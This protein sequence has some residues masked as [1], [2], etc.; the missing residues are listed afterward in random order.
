MEVRSPAQFLHQRVREMSVSVVLLVAEAALLAV[1][2]FWWWPAAV[3]AFVPLF[4]LGR[5]ASVGGRLDSVRLQRG[6]VGEERVASLL[7]ALQP[8]GFTVIH[9]LEIGRGNADHVL[10]GPTGVFVIETKD[11]GGRFYR[12]RGRLMFNQRP[13]DDVVG[14]VTV[15]ALA[16]RGRLESAG[17]DVWVRAVI[18]STR[19]S[20]SG[21]PL[22]LGHVTA[23]E[24]DDLP[25]FVREREETMRS[26]AVEKAVAAILSPIA[27]NAD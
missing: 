23:V 22:N 8:D 16:V 14:Q 13:A 9:D 11:W 21:S 17:M 5:A 18:A 3:A 2:G 7:D 20:V 10:V 6:I 25:A 15:A 26:G 19:A 4:V 24:A 12:R 27:K 1:A